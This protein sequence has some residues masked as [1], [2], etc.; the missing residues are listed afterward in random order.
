MST[1]NCQYVAGNRQR[2][3]NLGNTINAIQ[4]IWCCTE[5]NNNG[6][7]E[8]FD[9]QESERNAIAKLYGVSSRMVKSHSNYNLAGAV[10]KFAS[11]SPFAFN[12]GRAITSTQIGTRSELAYVRDDITSDYSNIQ[13]NSSLFGNPLQLERTNP[14]ATSIP[15]EERLSNVNQA[16]AQ[17]GSNGV[18]DPNELQQIAYQAATETQQVK[19]GNDPSVMRGR[20]S[21]TSRRNPYPESGVTT[22]NFD[23][24]LQNMSREVTAAATLASQQ[25]AEMIVSR[26]PNVDVAVL[27]QNA[28]EAATRAAITAVTEATANMTQIL[29]TQSV[30]LQASS[31]A[32]QRSA[33]AAQRSAEAAQANVLSR[34]DVMQATIAAAR[35]STED[36]IARLGAQYSEAIRFNQRDIV[37]IT[38]AALR[39]TQNFENYER[40]NLELIRVINQS[41]NESHSQ[42]TKVFQNINSLTGG[43]KSMTQSIGRVNINV[44]GVVQRVGDAV[45]AI[46]QQTRTINAAIGAQTAILNRLVAQGGAGG[47]G[48]GQAPPGMVQAAA[49]VAGQ[50]GGQGGGQGGGN[51]MQGVIAGNINAM[52]PMA[53]DI[54]PNT[55]QIVAEFKANLASKPKEIRTN[56]ESFMT[57][58][59]NAI[60]SS[61]RNNDPIEMD[62]YFNQIKLNFGDGILFGPA[63]E[64]NVLEPIR[65]KHMEY[66]TSVPIGL[67][68]K[69]ARA[70]YMY[71]LN[72]P[73][74]AMIKAQPVVPG[75]VPYTNNSILF[76]PMQIDAGDSYIPGLGKYG[77]LKNPNVPVVEVQL[78][79]SR[80]GDKYVCSQ[81]YNGRRRVRRFYSINDARSFAMRGGF[82]S[83]EVA[84]SRQ[85][86][87]Q[88][89]TGNKLRV[90]AT[91]IR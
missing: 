48:A 49:Q 1:P 12:A 72:M 22:Y 42:S 20:S 25:T 13:T 54:A 2:C 40:T 70:Y 65:Q 71:P 19:F 16:V 36:V 24:A 51:L 79:K 77:N 67:G 82:Y 80:L 27:T 58:I 10:P 74:K 41:R 84:K 11:S 33:D 47:V 88:L 86:G 8:Y 32:A 91:V 7:Y 26:M 87:F 64:N 5:H 89:N 62:D 4:G 69:Q 90:L 75:A 43:I 66:N 21:K 34:E 50:V 37:D 55:S 57:S 81:N 23:V 56:Y 45:T 28:S 15:I 85:A 59:N 6:R 17:A 52:Q 78:D 39:M 38:D 31:Q 73:D 35:Q 18:S 68:G 14:Q 61:I 60:Y 44:E 30:A 63:Y 76:E 29:N 53:I 9:L 3:P 46:S 83:D